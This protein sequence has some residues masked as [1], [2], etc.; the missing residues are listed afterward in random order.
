MKGTVMKQIGRIIVV[1]LILGGLTFLLIHLLSDTMAIRQRYILIGLAIYLVLGLFLVWS[2]PHVTRMDQ[3]A[4]RVDRVTQKQDVTDMRQKLSLST[5][6]Y[7]FG[8]AAV[9]LLVLDYL[10]R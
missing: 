6:G 1:G 4:H 9:V 2:R 5:F 10:I 7:S 8:L 3:T